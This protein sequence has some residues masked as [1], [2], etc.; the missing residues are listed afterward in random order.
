MIDVC[1]WVSVCVCV[2]M[3]SSIVLKKFRVFFSPPPKKVTLI[4]LNETR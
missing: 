2:V 3:V 4:L 1:V